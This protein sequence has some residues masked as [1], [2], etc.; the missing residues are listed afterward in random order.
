MLWLV[1]GELDHTQDFE[2]IRHTL[3]I[4]LHVISPCEPE[5][6]ALYIDINCI[7]TMIILNFIQR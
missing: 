5:N 3:Y 6:I 4:D 2:D 7:L 1:A